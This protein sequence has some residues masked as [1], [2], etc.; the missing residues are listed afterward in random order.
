MATRVSSASEL[1]ATLESASGGDTILL[2]SGDYGWFNLQNLKFDDHV[3]IKSADGDGGARFKHITIEG[4][5]HIKLDSLTVEFGRSENHNDK[6]IDIRNSNHIQV[7]N[8]EIIG[9][10]STQDWSD[11]A[12]GVEV[13]QDSSNIELSDNHIHHFGRAVFFLGVSDITFENNRIDDIRFDGIFVGKSSD[14]RIENN[15]LTDFYR[16]GSDH[17]DYIQF[18]PGTSG[19]ARDVIIRGN[20]MLK[21]K[22]NGDVQGI[23]G[24]N[25]HADVHN[26]VFTNFL[27]EDNIYFDTGLNAIQFYSGENMTVRNNT[28]LTDPADGRVVWVRLHGP[29]TDSVL[30]DNLATQANAEGGATASGNIIA[31]YKDPSKDNYYGDLF[32]DPFA[33]PVTLEDLAPK[34]GAI[35]SGKG[36]EQR[37]QELLGGGSRSDTSDSETSVTDDDLATDSSA[38]D[39]PADDGSADDGLAS[40][41]SAGDDVA[42]NDS[43]DDDST[44][45]SSEVDRSADGV[46]ADTASGNERQAAVK[47][48]QDEQ[49][50]DLKGVLVDSS[51][52]AEPVMA[53]A[54]QEGNDDRVAGDLADVF[55]GS[56]VG[57][58][59]DEEPAGSEADDFLLP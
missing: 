38:G 23:F 8:S 46:E 30:E 52:D 48:G 14:L 24:A 20:V 5:D 32:A 15:F 47:F 9:N 55:Q 58:A 59:L 43:S 4:S 45:D 13:W 53:E 28:V 17:A 34:P 36:A 39:E 19:A 50:L 44:D 57:V 33:D 3:T 25:H 31:Q 12:R 6:A 11:M 56:V 54:G 10:T 26:S 18:D 51:G 42:G 1:Q 16:Q 41:S 40:D 37:F 2:E 21:G 7:V 49:K 22:G 29:Q 35:G 27:V